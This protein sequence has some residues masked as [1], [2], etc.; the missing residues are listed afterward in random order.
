M[1]KRFCQILKWMLIALLSAFVFYTLYM[2]GFG[3]PCPIKSI[4]GISCPSCGITRMSI[5]FIHGNIR[6]GFYYNQVLPFILPL[7]ALILIKNIF[8][9]LF[10]SVFCLDSLDSKIIIFLTIVLISYGF[11][12]NLSFY[13]WKI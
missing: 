6:R 8:R 9:Y 4:T 5:A 7:L 3:I 13:P 12:R 1:K 10:S 2:L 11:I